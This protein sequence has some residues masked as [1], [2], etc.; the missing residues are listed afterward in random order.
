MFGIATELSVIV[1]I[2][3]RTVFGQFP[4]ANYFS[5]MLLLF[6]MSQVSCSAMIWKNVA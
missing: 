2:L 3:Q 5:N 6:E 1:G 4:V